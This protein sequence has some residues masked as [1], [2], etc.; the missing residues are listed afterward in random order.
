MVS[1]RLII[2]KNLD[3]KTFKER[4]KD[5]LINFGLSSLQFLFSQLYDKFSNS[6]GALN[7]I[8]IL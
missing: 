8:S 5:F 6:G 1:T 3:D 2:Y 7:G 4:G